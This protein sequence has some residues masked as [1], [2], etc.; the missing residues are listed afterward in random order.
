MFLITL[1]DILFSVLWWMFVLRFLLSWLPNLDRRHPII[2]WLYRLTDPVVR[3]FQ[4]V[5][6]IG[7]VDFSPV[8]VFIL[9]RL[10]H[11]LVMS[12]LFDIVRWVR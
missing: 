5:L 7:M 2:E 12:L 4:G 6:T 3:P 10:V 1:V 9:L 8:I 11:R